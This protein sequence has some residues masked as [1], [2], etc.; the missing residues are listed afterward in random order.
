MF[1]NVQNNQTRT[2]SLPMKR[3]DKERLFKERRLQRLN[4]PDTKNTERILSLKN[5]IS[6]LELILKKIQKELTTKKN[7]YEKLMNTTNSDTIV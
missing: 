4:K 6:N 5:E 2:T 3:S 1:T 7:L